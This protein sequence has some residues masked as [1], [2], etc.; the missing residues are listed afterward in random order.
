MGKY[1]LG[2]LEA[3]QVVYVN[4]NLLMLRRSDETDEK[5]DICAGC[6][7]IKDGKFRISNMGSLVGKVEFGV[8][9]AYME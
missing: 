8:E 4:W 7:R 5:M 3:G 9:I 1:G 2:K 6:W